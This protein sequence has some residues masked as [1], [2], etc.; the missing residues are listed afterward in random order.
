MST[1]LERK[2]DEL[3]V[4]VEALERALQERE[5]RIDDLERGL[6]HR[7]DFDLR[8]RATARVRQ[9]DLDPASGTFGVV[10]VGGED[11]LERVDGL[12]PRQPGPHERRYLRGS[13]VDGAARGP[14]GP[15]DPE[16]E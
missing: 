2:F 9:H 8:W 7:E 16:A 3:R 5:A 1:D 4:R 6:K 13:G 14:A 12:L 10:D 15:S 11:A